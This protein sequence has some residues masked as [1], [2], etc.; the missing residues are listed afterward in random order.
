MCVEII[1][2]PIID[3]V[4]FFEIRAL[5]A[6]AQKQMNDDRQQIFRNFLEKKRLFVRFLDQAFKQLFKKDS[7]FS[8]GKYGRIVGRKQLSRRKPLQT[9]TRRGY[10]QS[11]DRVVG[12]GKFAV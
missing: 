11:F 6:D 2:Y 8:G 10:K 12:R 4:D 3:V 1:F 7:V 9:D 5:Y